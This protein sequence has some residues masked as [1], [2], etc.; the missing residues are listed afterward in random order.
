MKKYGANM[1]KYDAIIS[2]VCIHT[3]I[4]VDVY[5]K[6]VMSEFLGLARVPMAKLKPG[7]AFDEWLQLQPRDGKKDPVKGTIHI[8]ILLDLKLV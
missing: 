8:Q 1:N 6:D 7:L 5:D 3:Y 2:D 4:Q